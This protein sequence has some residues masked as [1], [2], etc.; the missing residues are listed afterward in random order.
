MTYVA[1]FM[2]LCNEKALFRPYT[3][4]TECYL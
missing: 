4:Y 3:A 2:S 1:K